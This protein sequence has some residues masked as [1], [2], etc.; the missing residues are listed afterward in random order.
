MPAA[1]KLNSLDAYRSHLRQLA[2]WDEYLRAESRLPGPRANLELLEAVIDV[3][4]CTRFECLLAIDAAFPNGAPPNTPDEFLIVCAV[5]GLG[6]LV[7]QGNGAW[8]G[9]LR[10]RAADRRWR[11][12]EAVAI[13]LQHWGDH[14]L[15]A[16]IVEMQSWSGGGWLE[17]RAVIAALA[18]PRLLRPAA[19]SPDP[20]L[21]V[22]PI[23][24]AITQAVTA[25]PPSE[26]RTDD[27]QVLR[28]ALGYAWSVLAAA[29]FDACR[30]AFERWLAAAEAA[31]DKDLLWIARQNLKKNRLLV[32]DRAWATSWQARLE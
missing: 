23:F 25:A 16:L 13:G 20:A 19:G 1:R 9:E 6:K 12:R 3:G 2:D 18:E 27:Y 31:Q 8:L 26:R 10:R 15:P 28:Q 14:N 11:V 4:D 29:N 21:T 5:A 7:A 24:D 17:Q 30:P 32:L 22:L